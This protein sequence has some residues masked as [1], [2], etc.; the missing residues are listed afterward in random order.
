MLS[1]KK[2]LIK[3]AI[4]LVVYVILIY[5]FSSTAL[6]G[7][8]DNLMFYSSIF[9]LLVVAISPIYVLIRRRK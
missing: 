4:F 7:Y 3:A 1:N 6:V 2:R 8:N 5:L 9:A